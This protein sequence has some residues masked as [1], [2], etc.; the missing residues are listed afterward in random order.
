MKKTLKIM[1]VAI[2]LMVI[3]TTVNAYTNDELITYLTSSKTI[4]GETVTL[5]ADEKGAVKKYLEENPL[6]DEDAGMVRYY[7]ESVIAI[8]DAAETTDIT[9]LSDADKERVVSLVN[10][11]ADAAGVTV[12]VD[13]GKKS[14][15]VKGEDG[16]TITYTGA[17]YAMYI[18]PVVAIIAVA[19]IVVIKR[20]K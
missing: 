12:T 1:I 20:N 6:S 3:A 11:A 17:N 15:T 2:L 10:A 19:A 9:E 7:A 16:K 4:A 8:M 18:V 13:S 14:V 5:T